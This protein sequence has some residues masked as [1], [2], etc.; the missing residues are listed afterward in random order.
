MNIEAL[1]SLMAAYLSCVKTQLQGQVFD[2]K[3]LTELLDRIEADRLTLQR[4]LGHVQGVRNAADALTSI[5]FWIDERQPKLI[6]SDD[7]TLDSL[8]PFG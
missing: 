5:Q 4:A 6:S 3:A 1:K 7:D 8:R 2:K